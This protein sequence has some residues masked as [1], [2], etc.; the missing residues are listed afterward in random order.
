MVSTIRLQM[1]WVKR[2][3]CSYMKNGQLTGSYAK[4]TDL[5]KHV[6]CD[7]STQ[8]HIY[9]N[10]LSTV[11]SPKCLTTNTQKNKRSIHNSNRYLF[12]YIYVQQSCVYIK[13]GTS[14]DDFIFI[15]LMV[16]SCFSHFLCHCVRCTNPTAPNQ[17]F[18]SSVMYAH[19]T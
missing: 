13:N 14:A 3:V 15:N 6:Y 7:T 17:S 2:T 19:C 11:T 18:V 12:T 1:Y 8:Y 10:T 4:H 9:T 5:F 16:H